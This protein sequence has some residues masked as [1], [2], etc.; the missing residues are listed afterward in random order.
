MA[1]VWKGFGS[2][3]ARLAARPTRGVAIE[4]SLEEALGG[5]VL[6]FQ[7]KRR[8]LA[9]GQAERKSRHVRAPNG[10][11]S[12][13]WPR[14]K[15]RSTL[16]DRG[17]ATTLKAPSASGVLAAHRVKATTSSMWIHAMPCSPGTKRRTQS[18]AVNGQEF[19]QRAAFW[20]Q[21]QPQAHGHHAKWAVLFQGPMARSQACATSARKPEP[22]GVDS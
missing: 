8:H 11:G 5:H 6:A 16:V 13:P 7:Q 2:A 12:K 19:F 17:G 4:T 21:D 14:W 1:S 18:Q 9:H 10:A 22:A 3:D 15:R 20:R